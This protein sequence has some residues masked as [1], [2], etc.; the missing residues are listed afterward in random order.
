MMRMRSNMQLKCYSIATGDAGKWHAH[1][2]N[3]D[4][5]GKEVPDIHV[6]TIEQTVGILGVG[7]VPQEHEQ[8][9]RIHDD[10]SH[11]GYNHAAECYERLRPRRSHL[12]LQLVA[13][14]FEHEVAQ[15]KQ[16]HDG[17]E[18]DGV[19]ERKY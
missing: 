17:Q 2:E 7:A 4:G 14:E 13:L 3:E 18:C 9:L 10:V 15:G 8:V 11:E 12:A 6:K 1:A 16:R 19:T 5:H